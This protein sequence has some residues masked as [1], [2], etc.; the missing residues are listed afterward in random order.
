MKKDTSDLKSRSPY[1]DYLRIVCCIG[2]VCFHYW[3]CFSGLGDACVLLF[4]VLSGY[5]VNSQK[6]KQ[7][8]IN[9]YYVKKCFRLLPV[10]IISTLL[11]VLLNISH[12]LDFV[13]SHEWWYYA[14]H[15]GQLK[16]IL[17]LYNVAIWFIFDYIFFIFL[18][19][20]ILKAK[21]NILL[22]IIIALIITILYFPSVL[23]SIPFSRAP[24]HVTFFIYL[25]GIYVRDINI[26][27]LSPRFLFIFLIIFLPGLIIL[28][29]P[30]NTLRPFSVV[31]STILSAY[32][33]AQL[34]QHRKK[35]KEHVELTL[36]T[37]S[38]MT[39]GIF[40]LHHPISS[41]HY[42]QYILIPEVKHISSICICIILSFIFYKYVE[43]PC[44]LKI[45]K[46]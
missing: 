37:C 38:G 2:V 43:K 16:S 8:S 9:T 26:R 11:T 15:P 25:C 30:E 45:V 6:T 21:D 23:T 7:T 35:M 4:F 46:S 31:I 42:S 40:L 5:L 13:T 39:Y 20:F 17:E 19:P 44:S 29:S 41:S 28:M 18:T 14:A 33:I 32:L 34:S 24:I 22:F 3:G 36:S 27:P 10:L 12:F 1:L